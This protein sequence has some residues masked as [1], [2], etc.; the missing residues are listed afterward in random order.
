MPKMPQEQIYPGDDSD[1]D[2]LEMA[3]VAKLS[4][5]PHDVKKCPDSIPA[6]HHCCVERPCGGDAINRPNLINHQKKQHRR[7]RFSAMVK[8]NPIMR[9]LL[10]Y[11]PRGTT[12]KPKQG[13]Q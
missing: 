1:Q 7:H 8:S 12:F 6:P 4:A 2:G 5:A 9:K 13:T 10:Q 3:R 11:A